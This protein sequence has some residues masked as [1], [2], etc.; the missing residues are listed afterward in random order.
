M[1]KILGAL[2]TV[3]GMIC[4]APSYVHAQSL[5]DKKISIEV[6]NQRL[7]DVLKMISNKGDFYFSYNSSIIRRDSL[8]SLSASNKPVSQ[9]LDQLFNNRYAWKQYN[10]YII[11]RKA[12]VSP[13]IVTQAPSADKLYTVSGYVLNGE[14]GEKIS[15]ASIYEKQRLASTL[16]DEKGFFK[17][18]LRSRY[19]TATLTISREMFE[20]TTVVIQPRYNQQLTIV[21][22]PASPD[23]PVVTISPVDI[24]QPDTIVVKP[25]ADTLTSPPIPIE[26]ANRIEKTKVGK[27]LLSTKQHIQSLNLKKFI[28]D[29]T[30]Q[31]SL[32]PGLSTHG[33]LSAQVVNHFSVNMV[34][35]YTAG[36]NG[37]EMAGVFNINKKDMQYVQAAGFFNIVGG[38]VTGVQMAG[39]HN[40]VWHDVSGVQAAG[41]TNF[42]RGNVAGAQMSG[43][44]NHV[45]GTLTGIQAAG[46]SNY[47]KG[48]MT[49]AQMSGFYNHVSDSMTGLQA[50]GFGNYARKQVTGVQ[51]AGFANFA[52]REMSGAQFA[53]VFN[54]A[55]K[56]KGLQVGLINI[57]DTSS[58]YSIGLINIILK[59]YHKIALYTNE[60]LQTNMA[61]KTGNSKLYSILLVGF[62]SGKD[63]KE[64]VF[65]GGY[66]LGHEFSLG[67]RFSINPELTSQVLYLGSE[68]Y[69]NSMTKL[70]LEFNIKFGRFFSI[71]GGPS[72]TMY[73][74]DQPKKIEGYKFD[75]PSSSYHTF[76]LWGQNLKG[77][78][79]WNAGIAIF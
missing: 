51:M 26:D 73:Y 12:M 63:D 18:R 22:A 59:G 25:P 23:E 52:N 76:D 16:T 9:I 77:W 56:M 78:I 35:G 61:F 64:R 68:S 29:R 42:V 44:H 17:I 71:F 20:D 15:N 57:A 43:T 28:A 58:G 69:T 60:V 11:L 40:N 47:V 36:V 1:T 41:F 65:S 6:S 45:A 50:A 24:F 31:V 34:G 74:S 66:G 55:K 37:L 32:T 46:F 48:K 33:R 2:S 7:C 39:F 54:Y 72:F 75:I 38:S 21:M 49:G 14:T 79:G 8:V 13:N 27:F 4:L 5:L 3:I 53:P 67:K 30:F 19:S 70:H 62:N 10:N